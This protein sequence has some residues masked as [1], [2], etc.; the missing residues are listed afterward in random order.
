[1]QTVLRFRGRRVWRAALLLAGLASL[2]WG[3]GAFVQSSNGAL[4]L[5]G[6]PFRFGGTN[7]AGL[8]LS[9][10]TT[11]NQLLGTAQSDNLQVV[12]TWIFC[13]GI[14]CDGG[15]FYL[16]YWNAATGAP[17][18]ND[19]GTGLANV[20]YSIYEAG[21]LGIKLVVTLTDNWTYYGGMDTYV[22]WRGL[23]YHDQF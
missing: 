14:Q 1:M 17:A 7:S 13:D 20:D 15:P 3:Q 12:R 18:Y 9:N 8:M 10:Q 23:T 19:T 2:G 16:Q 6:S 4:T 5:D 21:K 11:V 22:T